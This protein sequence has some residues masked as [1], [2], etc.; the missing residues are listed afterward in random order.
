M[1]YQ[2]EISIRTCKEAWWCKCVLAVFT[3]ILLVR[4][5]SRVLFF[6]NQLETGLPNPSIKKFNWSGLTTVNVPFKSCIYD[7]DMCIWHVREGHIFVTAGCYV[8]SG[9]EDECSAHGILFIGRMV[10]GNEWSS[11]R[12]VENCYRRTARTSWF[13]A[14]VCQCMH[15]WVSMEYIHDWF[16]PAFFIP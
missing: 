11:V 7:G 16:V 12:F 1:S 5:Q 10:K 4:V 8:G 6:H 2:G 3:T 15:F 14:I 13:E 9:M